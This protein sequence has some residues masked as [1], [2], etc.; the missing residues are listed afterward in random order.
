ME[1]RQKKQHISDANIRIKCISKA[2]TKQRKGIRAKAD[3]C[4]RVE[5]KKRR[6]RKKERKKGN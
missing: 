3:I 5:T 4:K 1:N 6:K 2:A